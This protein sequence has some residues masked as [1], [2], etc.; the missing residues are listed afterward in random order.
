V[1]G[2]VLVDFATHHSSG[3]VLSRQPPE[4][5]RTI[6]LLPHT[7]HAIGIWLLILSVVYLTA[8]FVLRGA[9]PTSI[10]AQNVFDAGAF[11]SS[12]VLLIAVLDEATKQALGDTTQFLVIAGLAGTVYAVRA[13][14]N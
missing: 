1:V 8:A 4:W 7:Q 3:D 6:E 11:A 10:G 9:V 5:R 13:L 14:K 12:I 2:L